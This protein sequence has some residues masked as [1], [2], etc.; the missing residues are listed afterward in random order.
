MMTRLFWARRT[1][2]KKFQEMLHKNLPELY[3]DVAKWK[4]GE[5]R[6]KTRMEKRY[7]PMF[8]P[9]WQERDGKLYSF[10]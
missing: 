3:D 5:W 10:L 9:S 1:T 4:M 2:L 6:W 7:N 8:N